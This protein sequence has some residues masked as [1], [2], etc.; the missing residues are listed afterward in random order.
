MKD[1]DDGRKDLFIT[2]DGR[3]LITVEEDD[4]L[5]ICD[6]ETAKSFFSVFSKKLAES[7][8]FSELVLKSSVY[9]ELSKKT[10]TEDLLNDVLKGRIE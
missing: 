6:Y 4:Y 10:G 7:K 3:N 1:I 2:L 5:S 9:D 8:Y